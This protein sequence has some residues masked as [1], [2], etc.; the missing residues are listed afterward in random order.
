MI[1]TVVFD[2]DGT[3]VD[4]APDLV[5]TLNVILAREGLPAVAYQEARNMVGGGARL[6]LER[7]LGAQF[8]EVST[9]KLDSLVSDFIEYYASHIADRSTAFPDV[10][11]VLDE[12]AK[13]GWSLAVC[14]NKLEW[15]SHRL[16]DALGLRRR[17]AAVCGPDTFGLR[18]PDPDFL[19]RTIKQ[20]GGDPAAAVM[21]GDSIHDIRLARAAGIPVIAVD[22]GYSETPV[23]DLQPD[24][25]ISSYR[26]L[27]SAVGELIGGVPAS[28]K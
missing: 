5:N 1:A 24:R 14:T 23:R 4:S 7:G 2:L 9:I 6:L 25:L 27:P 12:F 16:L 13:A 10:E 21:V 15:L 8:G 20:A 26:E 17:F 22:F 18:K 3:L 11:P 28:P 19:R